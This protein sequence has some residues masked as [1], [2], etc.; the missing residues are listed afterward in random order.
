MSQI[1]NKNNRPSQITNKK[2]SSAS[3][4]GGK[5]KPTLHAL[6]TV[7]CL[8]IMSST[9]KKSV[10]AAGAAPA[11]G[12]SN[13]A[14]SAAPAS[15]IPL[16]IP[17]SRELLR[18]FAND[19]F[20]HH[21]GVKSFVV[22]LQEGVE[23]L[24]GRIDDMEAKRDVRYEHLV[25]RMSRLELRVGRAADALRPSFVSRVAMK[26][27]DSDDDEEE[28]DVEVLGFETALQ[29][30]SGAA[31]LEA[32]L[33]FH[34]PCRKRSQRVAASPPPAPR[35]KKRGLHRRRLDE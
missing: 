4:F 23:A 13:A 32:D 29:R 7:D 18:T 3:I 27:D 19:L 22:S 35:K 31:A 14:S 21:Q 17:S 1:A 16:S 28:P 20:A 25:S 26:E 33:G 9:S 5:K 2:N 24:R 6:I 11:D 12:E 34:T 8:P 15:P 30:E 10:N